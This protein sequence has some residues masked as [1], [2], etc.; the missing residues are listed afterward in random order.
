ME[1]KGHQE[2]KAN[3]WVFY[4]ITHFASLS[5]EI[6]MVVSNQHP[7]QLPSSVSSSTAETRKPKKNISQNPPAARVLESAPN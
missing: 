1:I 3:P 4:F 5:C 2:E 6:E 7:F